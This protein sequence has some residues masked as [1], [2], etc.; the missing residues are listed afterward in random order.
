MIGFVFRL[1]PPR[2]DFAFTM[3]EDERATM[4][5]HVAYWAGLAQEGKA[6]AFGPV[7]D[8][9]GP[10]G[11]GVVLAEDL[12]AAEAIR[13]ADPAQASEHGFRTE[14]SPMLSLVTRDGRFDAI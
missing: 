13:D 3:S 8:P 6:V 2:P 7:N 12:T 9:N 11:I 5:R 4:L 10:Y 1:L 14:I